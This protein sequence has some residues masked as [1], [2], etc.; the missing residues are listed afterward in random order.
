MVRKSKHDTF[1]RTDLFFSV[2]R[3]VVFIHMIGFFV[4]IMVKE[5][6]SGIKVD[7]QLFYFIGLHDDSILPTH[8]K[9][10]EEWSPC[11][12]TCGTGQ[13][14]RFVQCFTPTC[15]PVQ[16]IRPCHQAPCAGKSI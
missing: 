7:K 1:F 13:E 12:V 4:N 2:S 14:V 8:S 6:N 5:E 9:V 3:F 10:T 15:A 11:S 16:E